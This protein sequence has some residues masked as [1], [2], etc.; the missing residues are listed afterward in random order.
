[1]M[2]NNNHDHPKVG[3]T[4]KVRDVGFTYKVRDESCATRTV[5]EG[6]ITTN[7]DSFTFDRFILF[8]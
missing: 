8:H 7:F 1:M 3:F 5:A 2:H 6:C 4:Y